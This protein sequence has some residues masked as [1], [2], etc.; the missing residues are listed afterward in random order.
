MSDH[1][2]TFVSLN[3]HMQTEHNQLR[4]SSLL[5]GPELANI[6]F[7]KRF[8]VSKYGSVQIWLCMVHQIAVL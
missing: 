2:I 3:S 1:A 5:E 7:P 6:F 4:Y 8:W